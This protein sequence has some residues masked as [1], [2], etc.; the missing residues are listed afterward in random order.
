MTSFNMEFDSYVDHFINN[1]T[2]FCGMSSINS[3]RQLPQSSMKLHEQLDSH[4]SILTSDN[5]Y[6]TPNSH[7][8][9]IEEISPSTQSEVF[10]CQIPVESKFQ[11]QEPKAN[12][13]RLSFGT[14][15]SEDSL[16]R[17]IEQ[18]VQSSAIETSFQNNN[19]SYNPYVQ[20]DNHFTNDET[21]T[22]SHNS[23]VYGEFGFEEREYK[24]GI[25][26]FFDE[27][28]MML[29]TQPNFITPDF[30]INFEMNN[31]ERTKYIPFEPDIFSTNIIQHQEESKGKKMTMDDSWGWFVEPLDCSKL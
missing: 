7:L 1:F 31:Y 9:V 18:K 22:S 8:P 3:V 17:G 2:R 5:T 4:S 26:S 30:E 16:F 14:I 6:T 23:S 15:H 12:D 27:D 13:F 24:S 28:K 21:F 10:V 19:Q 29:E 25:Q 11:S 20:S